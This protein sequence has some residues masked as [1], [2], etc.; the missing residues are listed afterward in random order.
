MRSTSDRVFAGAYL[1]LAAGVVTV[2]GV[3]AGRVAAWALAVVLV[4]LPVLVAAVWA[5]AH[6]QATTAEGVGA[7]GES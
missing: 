6:Y 1:L 5:L 4:G 7:E 3:E 2:A